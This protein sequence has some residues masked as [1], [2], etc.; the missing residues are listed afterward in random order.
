[1]GGEI[2]KKIGDDGERLI[3]EFFKR[4]G[5]ER[6]QTQFNIDC[7]N[8]HAHQRK[9]AK[10][11]RQ[12]HGADALFSYICPYMPGVRR[13]ILVSVKNSNFEASNSSKTKVE[14]DIKE[15]QMLMDCFELSEKRV[16][17][18]QSGGA[19]TTKEIGVLIR[20]DRNPDIDKSLSKEMSN[21]LQQEGGNPVYLVDNERFDFIDSCMDYL[22]RKAGDR[23]N[24]FYIHKNSLNLTGET[25][26]LE[27]SFLPIQ[28]LVAGP[29]AI[30][31]SLEGE[32][33]LILFCDEQFSAFSAEKMIGMA[34][35]CSGGWPSKIVMVFND[36]DRTK[37]D[38]VES[39]KA[40]L[41]DGT[42]A[43]TIHCD[44]FTIKSRLQ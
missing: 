25:R 31:S 27:S 2:S 36:Y 41:D 40:R 10:N 12:T 32:K 43:S 18:Q 21:Q 44:S 7:A 8:P 4:I 3:A 35:T 19:T 30:R 33:Y 6:T 23:K 20:I 34:L 38:I 17:L 14:N 42:F 16:D 13:N 37:S 15:L 11:P 1:M 9:E 26:R 28:N 39:V 24:S 5:W 29:I 22:I